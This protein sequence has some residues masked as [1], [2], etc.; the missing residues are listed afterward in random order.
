MKYVIEIDDNCPPIEP[1]E[2][3]N[4]EMACEVAVDYV[5][6]EY[7]ENPEPGVAPNG[8]PFLKRDLY[9]AIGALCSGFAQGG[10]FA[11]QFQGELVRVRV[12]YDNLAEMM[13]VLLEAERFAIEQDP[14]GAAGLEDLPG[15]IAEKAA[16]LSNYGDPAAKWS[17]RVDTTRHDPEELFDGPCVKQHGVY[18]QNGRVSWGGVMG[19]VTAWQVK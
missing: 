10:D 11:V 2:F 7:E 13:Q 17:M 19:V 4:M 16:V 14:E 1:H 5:N 18:V 15:Y 12:D 6:D 3:D 8:R 9:A